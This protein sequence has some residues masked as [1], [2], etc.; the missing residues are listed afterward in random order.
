MMAT[1]RGLDLEALWKGGY[2]EAF[3]GNCVPKVA[4]SVR[5]VQGFPLCQLHSR[6]CYTIP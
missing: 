1:L 2:F 4:H 6:F 5:A 3:V